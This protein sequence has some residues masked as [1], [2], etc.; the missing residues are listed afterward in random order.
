DGLQGVAEGTAGHGV[1]GRGGEGESGGGAG[2]GAVWGVR[3]HMLGLDSKRWGELSAAVGGD[4]WR[5]VRYIRSLAERPTEFDWS[6]VWE[7][8]AHQWTLGSA[9]YAAL[10]H[11]LRL[12]R[13]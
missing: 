1:R 7:Q 2:A 5:V 12:G 4:G 9:A 6:E 11:L 3:V 8:I 13:S 10:P